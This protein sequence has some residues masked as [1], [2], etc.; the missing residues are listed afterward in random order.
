MRYQ[1]PALGEKLAGEYVLGTLHGAARARFE[2]LLKDDARLRAL[3][4]E[5]EERLA[6]LAEALP[7]VAPPARVWRRLKQRIVQTHARRASLWRRVE[8]WRPVGLAASVVAVALILYIG[9]VP[10]VSVPRNIAVL[11]N[12]QSQPAWLVSFAPGARLLTIKP[13]APQ[14]LG[15]NQ[16]FELWALPRGGQP[17][18]LGLVPVQGSALVLSQ[19][20]QQLLSDVNALAV[21]LEP[22]GGSPTGLPTGPVLYQGPWVTL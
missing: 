8:F 20:Q 22:A 5:W 17:H 1:D 2:A 11:S 14:T 18:S 4:V 3:V 19:G 13:L 9:V 10:Q 15:T 6:P 21:S 7:P 16:A 12:E